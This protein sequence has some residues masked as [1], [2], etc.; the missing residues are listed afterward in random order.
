MGIISVVL[1]GLNVVMTV[2]VIV[3]CIKFLRQSGRDR[4]EKDGRS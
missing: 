3:C 1:G 2:L 4:E